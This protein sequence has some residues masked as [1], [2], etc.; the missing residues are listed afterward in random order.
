MSKCP[1]HLWYTESSSIRENV[2]VSFMVLSQNIP[3][4]RPER[5]GLLVLLAVDFPAH[6]LRDM[7]SKWNG[8]IRCISR[9]FS[10]KILTGQSFPW[11]LW[12]SFEYV[13]SG[14]VHDISGTILSMIKVDSL[15]CDI[16]NGLIHEI[17]G[18]VL[19]MI[20]MF[21]SITSWNIIFRQLL[22]PRP[23]PP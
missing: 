17:R 8:S 13:I 6:N 10:F 19:F 9:T 14:R 15:A 16:A 4:P 22:A 18:T 3:I 11:Y 23:S 1:R 21:L 12:K 5:E 2:V 7:Y 20:S